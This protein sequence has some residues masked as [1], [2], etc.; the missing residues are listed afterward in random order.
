M[1]IHD[2]TLCTVDLTIS[3]SYDLD[4]CEY[5]YEAANDEILETYKWIDRSLEEGTAK[6]FECTN[7][8]TLIDNYG[9]IQII[10]IRMNVEMLNEP[11]HSDSTYDVFQYG[12]NGEGFI[13]NYGVLDIQNLILQVQC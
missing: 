5:S 6:H 1:Y 2:R 3:Y 13:N 10:G 9:Q 4:N 7:P 8:L 11:K 12:D